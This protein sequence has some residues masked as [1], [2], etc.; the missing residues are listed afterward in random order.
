MHA[1][2]DPLE[3][4]LEG[5]PRLLPVGWASAFQLWL[6]ELRGSPKLSIER[7]ARI[8][9]APDSLHN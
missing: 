5:E 2:E 3:A 4:L 1:P 9:V 8:V 6:P 7:A